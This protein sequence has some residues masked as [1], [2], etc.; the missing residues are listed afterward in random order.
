[1]PFCYFMEKLIHILTDN[2][3]AI[4]TFIAIGGLI[5]TFVALKVDIAELKTRID[6]SERR[7]ITNESSIRNDKEQINETA[8][9]ISRIDAVLKE[10]EK[11]DERI[12]KII[13]KAEEDRASDYRLTMRVVQHIN[14]RL[15]I[16][17]ERT[18]IMRSQLG[19]T[20]ASIP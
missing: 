13:E 8:K 4:S 14:N 9:N 17:E 10:L 3:A 5:Y 16:I 2:A 12:R 15:A 11:T 1:M 7:V 20:P 18:K 19:V 6:S